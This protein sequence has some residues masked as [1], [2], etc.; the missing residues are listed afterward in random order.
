M[1][2]S[3][4]LNFIMDFHQTCLVTVYVNISLYR[5]LYTSKDRKVDY[6]GALKTAL[7]DG[8]V[9]TRHKLST[10]FVSNWLNAIGYKSASNLL[11][12]FAPSDDILDMENGQLDKITQ[13][14]EAIDPNASETVILQDIEAAAKKISSGHI[15]VVFV[16]TPEEFQTLLNIGA[17]AGVHR[18]T[19]KSPNAHHK[20]RWARWILI[21]A[22]T[23]VAAGIVGYFAWN[24]YNNHAV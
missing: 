20:I 10:T 9:F 12:M 13:A 24:Y 23:L 11:S 4:S 22:T 16:R 17:P 15:S 3:S 19:T 18:I 7:A 14:I 21:G 1:S 8:C 6:V 5:A 2:S